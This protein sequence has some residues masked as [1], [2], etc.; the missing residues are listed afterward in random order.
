MQEGE[1]QRPRR[2][3]QADRLAHQ[4]VERGQRLGHRRLRLLL[5]ELRVEEARQQRLLVGGIEPTSCAERQGDLGRVPVAA[6]REAED[7]RRQRR[8]QRRV[9]PE[10]RAGRPAS[11]EQEAD[12]EPAAEELGRVRARRGRSARRASSSAPISSSRSIR[13]TSTGDAAPAAGGGSAS[14]SRSRWK[15][16]RAA[17]T[18]CVG[19]RQDQR[20]RTSRRRSGAPERA[21]RSRSPRAAA[22]RPR[23][24]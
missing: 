14:A 11:V 1:R 18:P 19:V 7:P 8:R 9:L 22:G 2:P 23:R 3:R 21:R 12:V 10:R 6:A 17:G 16:A 13:A 20:P 24:G 15:S 4:E 5:E